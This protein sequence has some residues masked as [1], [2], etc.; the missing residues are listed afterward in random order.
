MVGIAPE[1]VD[2]LLGERPAWELPLAL[3]A[4]SLVVVGAIVVVAL[5]AAEATSHTTLNLPLLGIP[6]VHGRDGGLPLLLGA[7]AL[8]GGKQLLD[9]V[10]A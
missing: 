6:S 5:R 10:R 7:G 9:R 4:W 1:R 8:L 2:N 3:L